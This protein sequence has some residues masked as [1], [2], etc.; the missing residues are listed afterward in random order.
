[1]GSTSDSNAVALS[2]GDRIQTDTGDKGQI[3]V[4]SP[5]GAWACVQ[6]DG[7]WPSATMPV[8]PVTQLTRLSEVDTR[9]GK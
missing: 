3:V 5:D 8:F 7:S 1:M 6:L 9:I 2:S 4:V